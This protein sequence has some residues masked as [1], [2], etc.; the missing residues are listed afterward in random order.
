M[1]YIKKNNLG[2]EFVISLTRGYNLYNSFTNYQKACLLQIIKTDKL[3]REKFQLIKTNNPEKFEKSK[4]LNTIYD[5]YNKTNFLTR[6][7]YNTLI[8]YPITYKD[9]I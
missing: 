3:V 9:K 5:F 8:A 2:G 7:Q 1:E 4:F 6:D